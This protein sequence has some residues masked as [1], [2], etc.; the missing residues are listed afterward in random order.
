MSC[1][2]E[3]YKFIK[4]DRRLKC[5]YKFKNEEIDDQYFEQN[6]FPNLLINNK[7]LIKKINSRE[8]FAKLPDSFCKTIITNYFNN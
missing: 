2:E 3:Y 7:F 5:L 6:I 4:Q 8:E 1:K